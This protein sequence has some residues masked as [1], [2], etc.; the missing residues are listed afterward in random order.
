MKNKLAG[1]SGF[2]TWF[3]ALLLAALAA[4]CGGG[5]DEGR[6]P[7]L[8]GPGIATVAPV[9]TFVSPLPNAT[10]VPVNAKI[11]TAAF[12][13]AMDTATLTAT[14]FTLAC[15]A[16]TAQAG[17]VA[18]A[19]TGNVATLTLT[20]NLPASTLCTA[21]I[22]TAAKDTTGNALASAFSWTFTT[23]VAT[24]TTP[25][26]VTGTTNANGATG[27]AINTAIG[28]TFSEVM[29][30]A[31]ITSANFSMRQTVSGAA[32]AGTVSYSGVNTV[33][34]PSSSLAN[35]MNYTLTIKGGAGGVTDLAGNTMAADYVWSWATGA[36]ADT[37]PPTISGTINANGATN[38]AINARD[39]ATFSEAM[40]PL[41]IN[42]VN[43][44]LKQTATGTAVA[45][46][47][48]YSGVSAVFIPVSNLANARSY[49]ATVKGGANGA[50]DLAGNAMVSDHVW[51]WTT[52]AL[53]DTTAP[54]VIGTVNANGATNVATN[55]KVGATFSEA[56]DPLSIT[57]V[58]LTLRQTVSGAAVA[59]T[60]SYSGVNAVLTPASALANITNYTATAKGGVGGVRDLAGN[61]MA[62]DYVWSWTTGA[63]ADAIAP[64]VISTAP[65]AN[66]TAVP[67]NALVS[68]TFSEA[69]DPLTIS[70]ASFSLACAGTPVTGGVGYAANS[71]LATLTPASALPASASCTATVS[72]A[73][74][75][76][77]GNAMLNPFTW[78]FTTAAAPVP[79]PSIALGS[80]STFGTFGGT[81]GMTNTG[82]LTIVNGDIGTIA[83]GTSAVT[84][85]HDTSGDI[86]T[87]SPAN[88]GAVNGKIYTCTNSTTGPTSASPNAA[89]CA[90]AT[91]ARLDAQT[92]YLALAAMP[93][94][95]NPG[96]NLAGKTLAAGTYTS[97][98]GSF[99]IQGADLTLDA[100]GNANATWVFQMAT[101]LTVGGPGAAAPQSI[102]LAGGAQAKNVFWQVGSA[103]TINAGG[104]GT[105][106]GTIISQ[107]GAAFST[108]GNVAILTLNGRALSLGASVT[109]VD[110]VINVPAP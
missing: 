34:V 17:T 71:N 50:K 30:P 2:L 101:S 93:P 105:M 89:A 108:A 52:G 70:T 41:T 6:S 67:T 90:I 106:V 13:K 73:V 26:T 16:G 102:I 107:A 69:M 82:T 9:V 24:D 37:T 75:D 68:A 62:S 19:A 98:S 21:T 80:A 104:G 100:Q 25:P 7:I 43:F 96:A 63:V 31:T 40:D 1:Y 20:N 55:T 74:K 4:G 8:G 79:V 42:T 92:A 27:V 48:S 64:T 22:T 12:N 29:A 36:A 28:A 53:L 38:V 49:T 65:S 97:P 88:I 46:V 32:V 83:T 87:E 45:G 103:A 109:L 5:G 3:M 58:N 11:V 85:F 66:A 91:Q 95:A 33:F 81:A 18:Y 77:A 86:Y 57:N 10:G 35:S 59:G 61:V 99:L 54:T 15:P 78:N 23:G 14:S 39:G 44:T 72:T 51:S 76:L 47:V 56:M 94:G 110:T 60:V 84:G